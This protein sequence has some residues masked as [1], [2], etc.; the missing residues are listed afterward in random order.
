MN[1]SKEETTRLTER[2]LEEIFNEHRL[3]AVDELLA[4]DFKRYDGH[5]W[6]YGREDYKRLLATFFQATPDMKHTPTHIAVDGGLVMI[7]WEATGTF[8][9][10]FIAP[11][12]STAFPATHQPIAFTGT[13]TIV[14]RDGKVAETYSSADKLALFS[15]LNPTIGTVVAQELSK[16]A[17]SS[18]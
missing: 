13:D 12:G 15:Q 4:E 14:I 3:D 18:K 6:L 1:M 9:G 8:S 7:R 2:W 11:G 16:L 5:S 17:P 10:D